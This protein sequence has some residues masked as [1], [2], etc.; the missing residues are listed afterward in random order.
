MS[1]T[2]VDKS[3]TRRIS[4]TVNASDV[5]ATEVVK[6]H[7]TEGIAYRSEEATGTPRVIQKD[8]QIIVHDGTTNKALFGRDGNGVYV[9]KVAKDTYDVLTATNDQLIFNS[10]Q[11]VFKI[12]DDI[13]ITIS[14][15][16]TSGDSASSYA[17]SSQAHGLGYKPAHEAYVDVPALGDIPAGYLPNPAV[18][19]MIVGGD[20]LL[21]FVAI[22]STDETNVNMI[23]QLEPSLGTGTYLFTAHVYLKQETT[24]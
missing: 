23:V 24:S 6:S 4:P 12:V 9:V 16:H 11:N 20:L 7:A 13:Y 21:G 3:S 15:N 2:D 5:L 1:L 19:P 8:D 17:A 14:I 10:A 18:V 22:V